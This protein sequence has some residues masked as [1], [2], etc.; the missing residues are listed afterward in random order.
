MAGT[1]LDGAGVAKM[2]TLEDALVRMQH[3][4]SLVERMAVLIKA[5][6]PGNL[7][8]GQIKRDASPLVGSLKGQFGMISDMVA[9]MILVAGRGGSELVKLR[10]LRESVAQ[11]KQAIEIAQAKV[12]ELHSV[13]I[14]TAD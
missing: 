12:K 4:N 3:L 2:T 9:N 13:E 8:V 14:V 10:S 11:I 5:Q 7:L 1:K 6:Q